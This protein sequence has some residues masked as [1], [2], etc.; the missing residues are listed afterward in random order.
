MMSRY[1]HNI[2]FRYMVLVSSPYLTR[3]LISACWVLPLVVAFLPLTGVMRWEEEEGR[4]GFPCYLQSMW[5]EEYSLLIVSC[6]TAFVAFA[7][8][9]LLALSFCRGSKK[10]RARGGPFEDSEPFCPQPPSCDGGGKRCPSAKRARKKSRRT[11]QQQQQQQQQQ[12]PRPTAVVV[13]HPLH[14]PS[15]SAAAS[16][17]LSSSLGDHAASAL[18]QL[19]GA[20]VLHAPA[21]A[22][23]FSLGAGVGEPTVT[24]L[25]WSWL[26]AAAAGASTP[27]A[28]LLCD[29]VVS[30]LGLELLRDCLGRRAS[31][32]WFWLCGGHDVVAAVGGAENDA[33][34]GTP[35]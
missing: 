27:V 19:A 23:S 32:C 33:F 10:F 14:V 25:G 13:I 4:S 17:A 24:Q 18:A 7:L 34:L 8:A 30:G 12:P 2:L 15:S 3:L 11:Q 5:T 28:H 29:D 1:R 35:T 31:S 21:I 26:A 16:A 20:I 9:T 22:L 6:V